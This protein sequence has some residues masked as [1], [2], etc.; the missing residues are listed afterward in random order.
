MNVGNK[1]AVSSSGSIHDGNLYFFSWFSLLAALVVFMSYLSQSRGLGFGSLISW[2]V[3]CLTSF[4]VMATAIDL[5]DSQDWC[6]DNDTSEFCKRA[7]FAVILGGVCGLFSLVWTFLASRL[8]EMVDTVLR[9]CV[10]V[11]WAAAVS[12]LTFGGSKA[13]GR[14]VGSLYFFTWA[15]FFVAFLMA[16]GAFSSLVASRPSSSSAPAPKRNARDVESS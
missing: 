10:A 11:P 15:S 5:L 12:L 16:V 2:P 6:D 4:V 1:L 3:L 7:R 13:P 14:E 9:I 8:P